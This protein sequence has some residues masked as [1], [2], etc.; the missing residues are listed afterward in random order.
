MKIILSLCSSALLCLTLASCDGG[1]TEG[2]PSQSQPQPPTMKVTKAVSL[3]T[4]EWFSSSPNITAAP[5]ATILID[6]E[7]AAFSDVDV[8]QGEVLL[9]SGEL[10]PNTNGL[11]P[12]IG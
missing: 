10:D 5:G 4:I 11:R 8:S 6:G 3:A 7:A 12:A 9:A 1:G 2:L